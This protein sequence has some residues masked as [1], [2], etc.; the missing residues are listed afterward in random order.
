MKSAIYAIAGFVLA[1]AVGAFIAWEFSPGLW[2]LE[3]R[4]LV[5]IVGGLFA[6]IGHIH[7]EGE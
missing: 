1:Y 2:A 6:V 5:A 7:G 4:G 3:W